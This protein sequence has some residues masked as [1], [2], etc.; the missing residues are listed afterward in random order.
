MGIESTWRCVLNAVEL[1]LERNQVL[2][3]RGFIS[4]WDRVTEAQLRARPADSVNSI[5]WLVWHM[6]RCEDIGVNRMA[7][8]RPQVLESEG[9][10]KRLNVPVRVYGTGMSDDEVAEFSTVVD[11]PALRGYFDAVG[12]R[13]AEVLRALTPEDLDVVVDDERQRTVLRDEGVI[14]ANA[15]WVP[16]FYSGKTKGW[17]VAHLAVTHSF[18]HLGGAGAIAGMLGSRGHPSEGEARA[19]PQWKLAHAAGKGR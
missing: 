6:A 13:T 19:A 3:T 12:R 16:Q 1:I 11:L 7:A 4:V 2:H 14:G 8:D 5:A 18:G 10:R 17:F 9:W 15:E